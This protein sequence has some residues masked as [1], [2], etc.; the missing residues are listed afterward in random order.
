[1]IDLYGYIEAL[2]EDQKR[3]K[4]SKDKQ[5]N[6]LIKSLIAIRDILNY[7]SLPKR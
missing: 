7:M 4:N 3:I 2:Q 6:T 5:Q 1:M